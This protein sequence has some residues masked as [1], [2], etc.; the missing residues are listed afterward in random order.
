MVTMSGCV[1]KNAAIT[2]PTEEMSEGQSHGETEEP[3]AEAAS[4]TDDVA[5]KETTQSHGETSA[6]E[7]E[8]V[9]DECTEKSHDETETTMDDTTEEDITEKSHD[10]TE[11]G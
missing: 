6:S 2:S 5:D 1:I 4:M 3:T 9:Y 8:T 7:T 10:E 11:G